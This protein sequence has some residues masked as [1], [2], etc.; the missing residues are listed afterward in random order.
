MR[1]ASK[2]SRSTARAVPSLG[3]L[4]LLAI[5][6]S[7]FGGASATLLPS[8]LRCESLEEPLG[9]DITRPQLSWQL[10]DTR[11]GVRQTAYEIMVASRA[12]LLEAGKADVWDSG[13]TE[14]AESVSV[15]YGGPALE[16]GHRYYWRVR[17]WDQEGMPS[18]YSDISWWEMGLLSPNDWHAQWIANDPQVDREDRR[19]A[20]KWIAAPGEKATTQSSEVND[21]SQRTSRSERS[22]YEFRL[23]LDF[24]GAPKEAT[25][26]ITGKN[27]IAAWVDGTPVLE[28]SPRRPWGLDPWGSF[29]KIQVG[30]LLR[31]GKNVLAA[32]TSADGP[33]RMGP[34][35]MIALLRVTLPDG[36]TQRFVSGPEWK[37]ASSQSGE[38]FSSSYDDS[39][40]QRAVAVGDIG[41]APFGTPWPPDAPSAFR[42][43][44][45]VGKAVRSARLYATALGSY[46]PH[47]NGQRVD[48]E[49]LAPGWTDYRKRIVY[50]TY[51]VTAK[52]RQ[53]ENVLGA[54]LGPGWYGSELTWIQQPYNFGPPPVRLLA[55]LRIQYDDGTEDVIGTDGSWKASSCAILSSE[56]Y[57]GETY[58]ARLEQSGWDQPSFSETGWKVAAVAP[59]PQATLVAQD[60]Q[61]IRVEKILPTKSVSNPKPGVYVFDLG[62]N[63][64]GWARLHVKGP[65]GTQVHMRFGEVLLPDGQFYSDNMRTAK[66]ADTYTLKGSG[67]EVFEPHFTYHGFRYVEVTGYPGAPAPGAIEGVVFH[68]DAPITI[69]FHTANTTVNQLWSNI[70]WGQRGNFESVP[71]DCP[72]RDE[73]LGWMGDAEVFWRTAAYNM[74]LDAFSHKFTA[75]IRDAQSP[76]G[77][78]ADVS[79]RISAVSEGAPGWADAGVIIPWTAYRQYRDTSILEENWPAMK[80]WMDHLEQSNPTYL[81]INQRNANYGDWLAIGSETS[82]DLIATAFWAYDASLMTQMA[83]ALHK[84]QEAERYERLFAKIKDAFN[85][86]FV[87]PD[88]TVGNGSQ[89]SYV[90]AL[91]VRLLPEDLRPVAGKKLAADIEAHQWHLTT[92]FLG[93]PYLMLELSET[94]HSDVAYRLLFNDTFPSWGYMIQHGATTMWERW[95]GDQMLRDPS[96]NSFNHYAYGAVG[97]WLYRY[98][99]GIDEDPNDSGFHRIVLHPQF[100]AKLGDAS[101]T[102][103]SPYG[104]ITS[105]WND[106]GDKV[107]WNIVVCPNTT[108]LL[109]FPTDKGTKILEA[110]KDIHQ[111]PGIT[112]QRQGDGIAVYEVGSGS[113]AFTVQK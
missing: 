97:E 23:D 37:A 20:A 93:T 94:G 52:L 42:R 73:R 1:T 112:F 59:A 102:Y 70:L 98:A 75:D 45:T 34:S 109:Y 81:W 7:S 78:F 30:V 82:K 85:H 89:T 87:K 113:Y 76:Q 15:S 3:L 90:L 22:E 79:P 72:Q 2:T 92:G 50:Q 21:P 53:G 58:D 80:R 13:R 65:R 8:H 29:R 35:A 106:T 26:F 64:V 5:V 38:W 74:N 32:E 108:G 36:S 96:M 71:T 83:N 107:S 18:A 57:N 56:L 110:G 86:A 111:S 11:R 105:A 44:F 24:S 48:D 84:P 33:Q 17:V 61:P 39:S 19:A 68:T 25:L 100:D 6:H 47:L 31:R 49:V 88:G 69:Q 54:L 99:A 41:Q 4:V 14:S 16:S 60:F 63:M 104:P 101:A 46:Q 55:Q 9:I 95:N 62:Q 10:Q 67:D 77:L 12:E 28:P 51:D 91:H 66:V 40:W 103:D 43:V 27:T